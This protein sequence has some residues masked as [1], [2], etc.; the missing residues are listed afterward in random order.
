MDNPEKAAFP[1]VAAK[2]AVWFWTKYTGVDLNTL[3]DGTFYSYSIMTAKINGGLNGLD[4][5][6]HLLEKAFSVF[7]CGKLSKGSGGT[8]S[9]GSK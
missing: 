7:K 8:C 3:A 4:K 1:S 9:I 5:R 2:V 6:T